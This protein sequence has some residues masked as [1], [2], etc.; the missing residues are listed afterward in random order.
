MAKQFAHALSIYAFV[1]LMI[2]LRPY[3]AYQ[4]SMQGGQLARDPEQVSRLLQR[5]VK[6]KES[7][8]DDNDEA[9]ELVRATDI[10]IVLPVV[11]LLLFRRRLAWL[12]ALLNETTINW[13]RTT[14]FQV[15]PPTNYLQ[16]ISRLQV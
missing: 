10:E 9:M 11:L 15:S 5:L 6:K 14:V 12:L 7:H 2:L 4:I 8:I 3:V 1:V 13:K 16:L